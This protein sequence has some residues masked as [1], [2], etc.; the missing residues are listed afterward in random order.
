M[1]EQ[2]QLPLQVN[3]GWLPYTGCAGIGQERS[4]A[5]SWLATVALFALIS[6]VCAT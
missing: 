2:P 3:I 6:A 5:T 4:S 1:F